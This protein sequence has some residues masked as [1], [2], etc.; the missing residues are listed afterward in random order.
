MLEGE[1]GPARDVV[2]LNAGAAIMVGGA[3]PDLAEGMD[4]A[5]EAIDSG[6]AREVLRRLIDL[7]GELAWL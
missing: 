7:T 2:M 4:R 1:D 6:A 5:R 3:A